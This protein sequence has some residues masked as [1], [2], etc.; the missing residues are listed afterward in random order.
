MLTG[1]TTTIVNGAR[2]IG[3]DVD[4]IG[5]DV[6][7]IGIDISIDV[8]GINSELFTSNILLLLLG[9]GDIT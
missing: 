2:G 4:D 1:M 3:I 5:I 8:A 6:D 9:N 7:D